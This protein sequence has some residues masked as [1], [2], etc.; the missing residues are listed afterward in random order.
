MSNFGVT[1]TGFSMMSL[2]DIQAALQNLLSQIKDPDTG[3]TL[4]EDFDENDPF[5]QVMNIFAD[6]QSA[7][8][9]LLAQVFAQFQPNVASGAVLSSLVQL[10]GLTRQI[11][12]PSTVTL[13]LTGSA[14]IL[15]PAGSQVSDSAQDVTWVIPNNTTLDVNTGVA[16]VTAESQLN[17]V[18]T[19][20]IS[21]LTQILTPIAG[22]NAVVNTTA[23]LPGT[24]DESD[25]SLRI[26]RDA[27]TSEPA[28]SIPEAIQ[29]AIANLTGVTYCRLY[30][31]N[32]MA[33]DG[34]SIP[35]K[36]L[37]MVVVGG[38]DEKVASEIFKR[39]PVACGTYGSTSISYTD[40][41]QQTTV[42]SFSR[43]ADVPVYL[44]I[45]ISSI[46]PSTFSGTVDP[47]QIAANIVAFA[48]GGMAAL[49][50]PATE[51]FDD[52]G[53]P[54]GINVVASRLY[55]PINIVPGLKINSVTMSLDGITYAATDIAIL[56]NQ[57][58][59]FTI[60]NIEVTIV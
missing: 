22:W 26:R 28:Q 46:D 47:A 37:A 19:A 56:W 57:I 31:N 1:S 29:A 41:L 44:K 27:S 48:A 18:F 55:S 51:G 52:Y 5:I 30:Q 12:T 15:V 59:Q 32:T 43:P 34:R 36:S 17:G 6:Q 38:S 24:A 10:N 42:V 8:W 9:D 20:P 40:S 7:Q 33:T 13:T 58:A 50:V 49:G 23:A 4:Q 3:E 21:T 16:T 11:G 54:P 60:S 2:N 14:G 53:F 39:M 25:S 45:S 35:A